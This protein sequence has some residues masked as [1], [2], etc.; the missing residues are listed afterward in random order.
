MV[1]KY[2][3]NDT[4]SCSQQVNEVH[5]LVL[6]QIAWTILPPYHTWTQGGKGERIYPQLKKKKK[7][8]LAPQICIFKLKTEYKSE[9]KNQIWRVIP[10]FYFACIKN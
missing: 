10:F 5:K 9:Q 1:E 7:K 4:I 6:F 2:N 8:K 3:P